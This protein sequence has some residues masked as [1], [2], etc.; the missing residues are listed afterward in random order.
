MMSDMNNGPRI[1]MLAFSVGL[2]AGCNC[3]MPP[4]EAGDGGS[5]G[6]GAVATGGGGT[7]GGATGGGGGGGGGGGAV[8]GGG[9]G[10]TAAGPDVLSISSGAGRVGEASGLSAEIQI[11]LAPAPLRA[12][13]GTFVLEGSAVL[14][15]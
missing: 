15:P 14:N 13:G 2:F 10:T 8:T 5:G 7:G 4:P 12:S 6:G 1:V 3:G 9:G 11:G